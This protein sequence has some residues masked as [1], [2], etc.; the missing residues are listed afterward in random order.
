MAHAE[1]IMDWDEYF[2]NLLPAIS[3]KSKLPIKVGYTLDARDMKSV[4]QQP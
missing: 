3:S 2:I 1:V 4:V